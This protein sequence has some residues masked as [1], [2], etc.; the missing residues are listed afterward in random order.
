MNGMKGG[1]RGEGA[2]NDEHEKT[3]IHHNFSGIFGTP[4]PL[5]PLAPRTFDH[6]QC[7]H[8]AAGRGDRPRTRALSE[9]TAWSH[10]QLSLCNFPSIRFCLIG[11]NLGLQR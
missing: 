2:L 4:L 7:R 10:L 11:A 5:H 1:C 9:S 3:R 6:R 8:R